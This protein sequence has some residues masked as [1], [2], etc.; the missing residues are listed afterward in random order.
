MRKDKKITVSL[1]LIL[2]SATLIIIF[3]A[4]LNNP[5]KSPDPGPI[6]A[7]TKTKPPVADCKNL[8][9]EVKSLLNKANSC[10]KDGDCVLQNQIDLWCPFGCYNL[11]NRR[12]DLSSVR[13]KFEEYTGKGCPRCVYDCDVSPKTEDIKCVQ[14]KCVDRRFENQ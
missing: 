9:N 6:A 8:E 10:Q 13:A 14:N 2:L 12:A 11:V 3:A 7:P 4:R 5:T 1:L